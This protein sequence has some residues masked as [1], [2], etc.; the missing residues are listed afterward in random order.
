MRM[1]HVARGV[2]ESRSPSSRPADTDDPVIVVGAGVAGLSAA[3]ELRAQGVPCVLLEAGGRIGGRAWTD[4]PARLGGAAF[5]RGA[6][7]LHHGETNPLTP[8]AE[9]AG[10]RL[11]GTDPARTARTRIGDRWAT[12]TELAEYEAAEARFAATLGAR[13]AAGGPDVS[14]A[15]AVDAL[16]D[17]PWATTVEAWEGSLIAAAPPRRLS[18]RDWHDNLLGGSNLVVEGGIGQFVARRLGPPAGEVRL[19][20]A[21]TAIAWDGAGVRVTSTAGTLAGRGCIVTVSTGVLAAG[22]IRFTPALPDELCQAI[23]ALP[24]GLLTKVALPATGADRLDLPRSCAIDRCLASPEEPVLSVQ[25]WPRGAD[26]VVCFTGGAHAWEMSRAG[27]AALEA[28]VRGELRRLFGAR[29]DRALGPAV[30]ADW[31]GEPLFRGSYAY[32]LPGRAAARQVLGA[33]FGDGRLRFAGEAVHVGLAG[34]V[35][36]AWLTG[37]A[38]AREMVASG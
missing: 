22:G 24:M 13:V 15:E 30:V 16:R 31:G 23:A 1:L 11:I 25:A 33:R 37:Q 12:D 32:A 7:W 27:P 20:T 29:A 35:G 36:G 8:I 26:H 4:H 10:D 18:L 2:P 34:T 14:L 17:D 28:F 3:A 19:H 21:V 5:D 9:R 38:A 6:S